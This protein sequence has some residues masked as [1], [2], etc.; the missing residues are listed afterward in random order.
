MEGHTYIAH[1]IA[2]EN[3]SGFYGEIIRSSFSA[4]RYFYLKIILSI[5]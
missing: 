5:I 2:P 4:F 3:P 1:T